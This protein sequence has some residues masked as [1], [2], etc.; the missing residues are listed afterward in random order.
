MAAL[1]SR[2]QARARPSRC[3]EAEAGRRADGN[4]AGIQGNDNERSRQRESTTGASSA[5]LRRHAAVRSSRRRAAAAESAADR[6]RC[7]D[8]RQ[9]ASGQERSSRQP[10][11][12]QHDEQR[13]GSE[14]NEAITDA[15]TRATTAEAAATRRFSERRCKVGDGGNRQRGRPRRAKIDSGTEGDVKTADAASGAAAT[16]SSNADGTRPATA[17]RLEQPG[18]D[19]SRR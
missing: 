6:Q 11:R 1:A 4:S 10:D 5:A 18:S 17:R 8:R 19:G 12:G 13:G 3:D 2:S 14:E 7:S 15:R 16:A 9:R